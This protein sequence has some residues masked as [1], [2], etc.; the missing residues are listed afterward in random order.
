[1]STSGCH[2][3][4]QAIEIIVSSLN[5]ALHSVDVLDI[6]LDDELVARYGRWIPVLVDASSGQELGWPFDRARLLAFVEGLAS[7]Q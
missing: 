5:P 1:M 3:C 4:D 2:L 7:P 6:A